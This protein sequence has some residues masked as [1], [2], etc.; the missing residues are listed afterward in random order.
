MHYKIH[1]NQQSSSA[2]AT[3]TSLTEQFSSNDSVVAGMVARD[4]DMYTDNIIHHH[5]LLHSSR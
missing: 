4:V 3:T 5:F 1:Y 2:I